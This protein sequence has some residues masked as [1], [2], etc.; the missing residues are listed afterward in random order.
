MTTAEDKPME[1]GRERAK[2]WI[3]S[4]INPLLEAL[5]TQSVFVKRRNWTFR[6]SSGNLEFIRP[7]RAYINYQGRPNWEDFI[8]SNPSARERIENHDRQREELRKACNL[9]WFYLVDL[10]EFRQKVLTLLNEFR[11]EEP[12]ANH[13]VSG[14]P[15]EEFHKLVAERIVNDIGNIAEDYR[16]YRFWSRFR[17]DLIKFRRGPSFGQMEQAGLDLSNAN[18]EVAAELARVREELASKLDIPWAPYYDES[19]AV[20]GR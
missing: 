11:A 12:P 14:L 5:R 9:A 16:D 13:R 8:S 7:L 2:A 19:L 18:D 10:E 3:Y 15:D 17:D 1:L 4:V 6:F 20:R